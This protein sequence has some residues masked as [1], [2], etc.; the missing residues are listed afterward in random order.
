MSSTS[1]THEKPAWVKI[2][3][4][5]SH[6]VNALSLWQMANSFIPYFAL[7][8]LAYAAVRVNYLLCVP[9]A[10][11]AGLFLMRIF[12]IQHDCGHQS[13]FKSKVINDRIGT[14]CGVLSLTPYSFWRTTHAIHHATSGDLD[15]RGIGDI[16]TKTVAEYLAL[17]PRGKLAYRIYRNPFVM[18]L[19]GPFYIFLLFQRSPL[20]WQFAKSAQAKRSLIVT[21]LGLLALW[22]TLIALFGFGDVLKV[23]LTSY[24]ITATVGVWLFYVQHNF[25]DTYWR[26]HPEWSYEEAA[27]YGSS[28][29]KL[30]KIL[31]WFSG[32][33]GLHHIHHLSPKIPNYLLQ[34][35][36]DEN[37]Y[38]RNAQVLTLRSSLTVLTSRVA[39]WDEDQRKMVSFQYV[40]KNLMNAAA[41][42]L[43]MPTL[44]NIPDAVHDAIDSIT[45]AGSLPNE[46]R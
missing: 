26:A 2:V 18:F 24:L 35:A 37:E 1:V 42:H 12:I 36:Y 30:P 4:Q 25:E 7:M 38:L 13:F 9:P 33:I 29:Y 23:Q 19:I 11:L 32:N 15:H 39:M 3:A 34:K 17:S 22:G 14:F 41:P 27:I 45:P 43:V 31:Q 5:Y 20:S 28:Y 40:H 46:G 10:V 16:E 21:D 8:A 44:P 6:S